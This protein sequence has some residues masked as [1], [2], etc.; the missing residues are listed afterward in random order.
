MLIE[1]AV[2]SLHDDLTTALEQYARAMIPVYWV[3]DVPGRRILVHS[4]PRVADGRG[5]YARID[6]YHV[7]QSIL[8]MLDG[9]GVAI[10]PFDDL[11]R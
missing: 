10:I 4:Q 3:V 9:Q 1:I 2:T 11:L 7:G 5:D 6:I 8:L